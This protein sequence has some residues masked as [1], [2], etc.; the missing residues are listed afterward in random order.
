MTT[1]R[2]VHSVNPWFIRY[3]ARDYY[4]AHSLHSN[5]LHNQKL[6]YN[7]ICIEVKVIRQACMESHELIECPELKPCRH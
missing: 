2:G 4:G 6:L 3:G 1:Y 5:V 7:N